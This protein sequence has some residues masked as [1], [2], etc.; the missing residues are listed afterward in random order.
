MPL[1]ATLDNLRRH[2]GLRDDET[3]D[4]DRL[5]GLLEAVSTDLTR[6]CGRSFEPLFATRLHTMERA[7]DLLSLADDLLV[8]TAAE[9]AGGPLALDAV[10]RIPETGPAA[11]LRLADGLRFLAGDVRVTG[12]WGWH[13]HPDGVWI[14]TGQA[15]Q[16]DPLHADDTTLSV[17]LV[18]P[19]SPGLL[20]RLEGE[21]ARVT[22]VSAGLNQI[23]LQ[24]GQNGT[25]AASHAQGTPI[26]GYSAPADVR[27]LVLRRAAWLARRP[28]PLPDSLRT[29]ALRWRRERV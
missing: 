2:L 13:D 22:A 9:D 3:T 25:A 5:Y 21:L 12:W 11:L 15:V 1:Y 19:F 16:N 8:L 29:P 17:P 27:D 28:E 20:L 14:A 10:E 4:D 7:S 6:E 26:D 24:R 18:A 23:T